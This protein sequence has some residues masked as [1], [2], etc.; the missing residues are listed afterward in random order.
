MKNI[1]IKIFK[2]GFNFQQDG[3][4]NRLILHLQGC[5]MRCPWCANPEGMPP[6]GAIII[7]RELVLDEM[8]PDGAI[9]EGKR[10][11][12]ICRECT[13]RTCVKPEL[14]NTGIR[15]SYEEFHLEELVRMTIEYKGLFYGGGGVTLGGGEAT[16]QFDGVKELLGM[17]KA[18]DIN[19]AIET[20][21]T[22][23]RLK[24]L[25]PLLDHLI[26][27][28]KIPQTEKHKHYTGI[29]NETIKHNISLAGLE[30]GDVLIRTP[31]IHGVNDSEEDCE[32]FLNF[33]KTCETHN[34]A[35]EF[36]EYHDYGKVK[37][38]QCGLDY[39]M[40][41]NAFVD[42]ETVHW[43]T[44]RYTESGLRVVAT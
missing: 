1:K 19:T 27:D 30:H 35:F 15:I 39:A 34:M 29:G 11:L 28:F 5:N 37:W 23:P 25:F 3:P 4:G 6:A 38:E 44:K 43:F 10:N 26:M 14:R 17:L 18:N 20:N 24:E 13:H 2:R 41:D 32:A 16:L 31:L 12:N 8:C 9:H 21:A 7:N 33:Y 40:D 42:D 22:S 36:L